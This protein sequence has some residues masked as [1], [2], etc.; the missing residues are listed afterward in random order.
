[1]D[2]PD[3][4]TKAKANLDRLTPEMQ[5]AR[6]DYVKMLK[7]ISGGRLRALLEQV[8]KKGGA[9]GLPAALA[10]MALGDNEASDR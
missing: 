5:A 1:M 9:V 7:I 10:T 4:A 2:N 8:A 6:P 3:V